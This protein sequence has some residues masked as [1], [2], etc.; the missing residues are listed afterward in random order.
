MNRILKAK[1]PSFV[2]QILNQHLLKPEASNQKGNSNEE[3]SC[4][5]ELSGRQSTL[6]SQENMGKA[7]A[8][9]TGSSKQLTLGGHPGWGIWAPTGREKWGARKAKGTSNPHE[10]DREARARC[11]QQQWGGQA[12]HGSADSPKLGVLGGD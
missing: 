4:S 9:A 12:S 5:L 3:G 11:V 8:C 2:Q 1:E 6:K 7:R 10:R